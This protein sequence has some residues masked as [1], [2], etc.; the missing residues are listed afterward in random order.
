MN[1]STY[2]DHKI[3]PMT[4]PTRTVMNL[5]YGHHGLGIIMGQARRRGGTGE[6]ATV[7]SLV[8][9]V[10][11]LTAISTALA[12]RTRQLLVTLDL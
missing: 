7:V 6:S 11:A 5:P 9:I 3:T 12:A 10:V 1:G 8:V 2:L 4:C